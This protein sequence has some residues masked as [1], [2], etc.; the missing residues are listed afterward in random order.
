[1]HNKDIKKLKIIGIIPARYN[2][3]RLPGK[4]LLDI[5]GKSMIRRVYENCLLSK[6]LDDIIIATDD[7]R[8]LEHAKSFGANVV[9]TSEKI[10]TGTD[11]CYKAAQNQ[12]AD[13]VIN[14]QGDEPLI[15]YKV[16]DSVIEKLVNSTKDIV[17]T[18]P[19][20]II[21]KEEEIN[22]K[23]CVKVVFDKEFNA[24]YFSR[25]PIPFNRN[26]TAVYYKH[27]GIYAYRY[28]FL[29]KYV[30]LEQTALEKVESLEQLRIL[31]N[32]FKIKCALVDYTA[33]GVDTKED[34]DMVCALIKKNETKG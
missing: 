14:I 23:N 31:E 9:L 26:S 24:L 4:P 15:D 21:K 25:L 10:N 5:C 20:S 17:C 2:S 13:I 18:T 1:M 28:D 19:I 3:S 16:I 11:R 6:K 29:K 34:L 32:G 12:D 22:S 33:I 7:K 27:I 8:I 30:K